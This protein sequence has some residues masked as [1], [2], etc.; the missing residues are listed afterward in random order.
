MTASENPD[1][2]RY[3]WPK[4][5]NA[6]EIVQSFFCGNQPATWSQPGSP[7]GIRGHGVERSGWLCRTALPVMQYSHESPAVESEWSI[8]HRA[9]NEEFKTGKI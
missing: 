7:S 6:R 9:V 2:G 1:D 5:Q 3:R 4:L 8:P